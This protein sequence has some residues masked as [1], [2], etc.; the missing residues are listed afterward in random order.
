MFK[1]FP[2][3]PTARAVWLAALAAPIALLVA[4]L[5][6]QAWLI[7]PVAAVALILA[8]VADGLLAGRLEEWRFHAPDDVEVGEPFDLTVLADIPTGAASRVEA[9]WQCDPRLAKGGMARALLETNRSET[10]WEGKVTLHANRRGTGSLQ[11]IWL[12]WQGPLGLGARQ[13]SHVLEREVRIWPDLAPIRSK[14]L[15]TY[16]R[17]AELG[18]IARRQRGEGTQFESLTEYD[19]GMDRRT[20]DW[21]ASSRHTKLLARENESERNNQIV[22]AFDCGKAMCEP[23]DGVPRIDRAVTAGLT[24]AYVALKGG[25]RAMLFGF[26]RK[27]EVI[28]PFIGET[29]AFPQLQQAAASLDYRS[30]EPN[31]TLGLATLASQLRRRSLIVLFSEFTD[32]TSAEMM[33]ESIARLV[34]K[35]IVLFV[36]FEDTELQAL[37]QVEPDSLG[38][39]ASAVTADSLTQQ[40]ALVHERLRHMGVDIIEAP[41]DRIGFA[42][43]DRYLSIRRSEA[44]AG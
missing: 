2:L 5:A 8:V 1:R 34:E 22:F 32:P 42:V 39:I 33:I 44:I 18:L 30:E 38:A 13:V 21:K 6:P 14:T 20:I 36:A 29:R 15:Q 25:D 9:A 43:I 41:H 35:H 26:A 28:T 27:P 37:Q 17:D 11:R 12:N 23:L 40:R 16:L 19:A 7:A 31:F 24:G 3:V 4:L 10:H